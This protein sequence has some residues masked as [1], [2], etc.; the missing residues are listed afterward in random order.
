VT[1]KITV[2]GDV[3][4]DGFEILEPGARGATVAVVGPGGDALAA[5]RLAPAAAMLLVDAP[6]DEVARVLA[7]TLWPRPR[8]IGVRA[9][10]LPDAVHAARGDGERRMRVTLADG[11]RD[12][13][14]GLCGVRAL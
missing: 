14:L 2:S 13:T 9:A 6:P 1:G 8:V 7:A 12:V 11:E 10:D 5:A 4:L 3:R